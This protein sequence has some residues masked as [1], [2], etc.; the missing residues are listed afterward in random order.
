MIAGTFR[1]GGHRLISDTDKTRC[2]DGHR[3]FP[4][5]SETPDSHRRL[6]THGGGSNGDSGVV[7]ESGSLPSEGGKPGG[8]Y[9]GVGRS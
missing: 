1:T 6:S 9:C 5:H 3:R 4:H 7:E 8:L 2:S